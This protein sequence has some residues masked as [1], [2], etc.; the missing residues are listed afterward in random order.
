MGNVTIHSGNP[1]PNADLQVCDAPPHIQLGNFK[2]T[3]HHILYHWCVVTPST[4]FTAPKC[5]WVRKTSVDGLTFCNPYVHHCFVGRP[6]VFCC[7]FCCN[8]HFWLAKLQPP[9]F[10]DFKSRHFLAIL[11]E[12]PMDLH[13]A[14]CLALGDGWGPGLGWPETLAALESNPGAASE[15]ADDFAQLHSRSLEMDGRWG[16]ALDIGGNIYLGGFQIWVWV[17]TYRYIFSGMNIHLPAILGFTRY[18]GFDPSAYGNS[19]SWATICWGFWAETKG[20]A[21]PEGIFKGLGFGIGGQK[22]PRSKGRACWQS[23]I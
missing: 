12:D 14:F 8:P 6:P 18:Q 23:S 1:V 4:G 16:W 3:S 20:L 11:H 9:I 10:G 7:S 15:S 17:N 22:W 2:E 21:K 13:W 5:Y 19:W